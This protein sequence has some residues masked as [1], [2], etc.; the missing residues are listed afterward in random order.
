MEENKK[1]DPGMS[2]VMCS[3]NS[4][5][6]NFGALHLL[7]AFYVLYGHQCALLN[8]AT[9]IF[10]GSQI[11]ALGVKIIFLISGYLIMKSL[12]SSKGDT[13]RSGAVFVVKRLGRLLPELIFV[14]TVSALLLGSLMTTLPL[15]EYL[16]NGVT[17]QY[18]LGNV[19]FFPE[20]GLPGVF[21]DN[22]YVGAVNG[23]LWTMPVEVSLYLIFLIVFL[24]FRNAE[25]RRKVY[26]GLTVVITGLFLI[27]L[28]IFPSGRFVFY[29]TN[30]VSALKVMPY[31]LLGGCAYLVDIRKYLNLQVAIFLMFACNAVSFHS[32]FLS[33]L[34][35]LLTLPYCVFALCLSDNQKIKLR[36]LKGEYA[37]G[38]YLWGFPIQQ[39][40]IQMF[41]VNGKITSFHL[42][43]LLSAV[44]TYLLAAISH[45]IVYKPFSVWNRKLIGRIEKMG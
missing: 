35:C 37:Y 45:H 34:L 16:G 10:F 5:N 6:N 20:Y 27:Q 3:Q 30:W 11:Q 31:M 7:A 29:G 25:R 26:I 39:C 41:Y 21:M 9:P 24:L 38:I 4:R 17:W 13:A 33:E 12:L 1:Q 23:S 40:L 15:K 14:V 22:P 18:I 44:I 43:F 8:N 32:L 42:L 19:F 2:R 36:V 28:L